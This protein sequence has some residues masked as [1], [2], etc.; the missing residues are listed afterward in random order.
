MKLVCINH[1]TSYPELEINKVYECKELDINYILSH[2]DYDMVII[3]HNGR[4]FVYPKRFFIS[5][6]ESRNSKINK[7]LK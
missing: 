6:E 7:I 1:S 2:S 3:D 5:I 4:D